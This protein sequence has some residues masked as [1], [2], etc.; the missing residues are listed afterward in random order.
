MIINLMGDV[1]MGELLETYHR[2]L[3]SLLERGGVD[4][5]A[6]V[7]PILAA[8]HLNLINLECVFSDISRLPT[9]FSRILI[10]PERHVAFLTGAGVNAV[11]TANNH[12]LDHG[13]PAFQRSCAVLREQGILVCGYA[14]DSFFQTVPT[15]FEHGDVRLGL[16]GYN[17][18][19]FTPADREDLMRRVESVVRE[20]RSGVDLLLVSIHWGEEYANV[21]PG[22]VVNYGKRLMAAGVDIIH[23]HHSH[24]VQ[25]VHAEPGRIFAPSLGNFVFDQLIPDNRVTAILQVDTG[26]PGLSHRLTPCYMNGKYQPEPSAEHAPYLENLTQ[27]LRELMQTADPTARDATTMDRVRAGHDANRRRMRRLMLSHFWDYLPH[28]SR[29]RDYRRRPGQTFSIIRGPG[30]LP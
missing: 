5:F 24:Q 20:V 14:P 17:I 30:N 6:V 10:A 2:G 9:P 3:R 15:L 25:G 8:G 28:L 22:Y 18:S 12:A 21:P 23:G 1:M 4:P 16:L 11:N 27:E 13:L 26:T 19:N 7:R 29:I